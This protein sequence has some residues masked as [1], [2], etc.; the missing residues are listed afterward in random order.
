MIPGL[1]KG[2]SREQNSATS[3]PIDNKLEKDEEAVPQDLS[4]ISYRN[5]DKQ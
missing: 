2:E 4:M 3:Q 1:E 5:D